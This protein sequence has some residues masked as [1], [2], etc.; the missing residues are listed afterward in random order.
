MSSQR[1]AE[2]PSAEGAAAHVLEAPRARRQRGPNL[3]TESKEQSRRALLQAARV[4][5]KESGYQGLSARQVSARAGLAQSSFY[6]HFR[7]KE[8]LVQTLADEIFL[9]LRRQL[10]VLRGTVEQVP[11]E[12]RMELMI[13][14]LCQY[15]QE[16]QDM[17]QLIFQELDHPGSPVGDVA[18]QIFE[19]LHADLR[20]DMQA[21]QSSGQLPINLPLEGTVS[22]LVGTLSYVLRRQL[23]GRVADP[24]PVLRELI[25]LNSAMLKGLSGG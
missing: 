5:L 3:R 11:W 21:L 17:T 15:V 16:E 22:M 8:A 19:I 4:V 2:I 25:Q 9:P 20:E 6:D 14:F 12:A 10:R 1:E 23:Q 13:V 24:L 18:R 7:D